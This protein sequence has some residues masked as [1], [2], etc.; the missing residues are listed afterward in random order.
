MMGTTPDGRNGLKATSRQ[1]AILR[2]TCLTALVQPARGVISKS[3]TIWHLHLLNARHGLTPV[4]AEI[5]AAVGDLSSIVAKPP[6]I[7]SNRPCRP[8]QRDHVYHSFRFAEAQCSQKTQ[9][10]T[11][12]GITPP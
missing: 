2:R 11:R 3:M 8:D 4:M 1:P 7:R 9:R 5:R 6:K 10:D 12:Q